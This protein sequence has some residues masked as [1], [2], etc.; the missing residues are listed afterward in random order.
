MLGASQRKFAK[1]KISF[2][3]W[4]GSVADPDIIII[5]IIIIIMSKHHVVYAVC[6]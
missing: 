4:A 6:L 5:I 1:F 2:K 3:T